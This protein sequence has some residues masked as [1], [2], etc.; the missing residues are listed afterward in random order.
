MKRRILV[1]IS[2]S[3]VSTSLGIA[4]SG[5]FGSVASAAT[6]PVSGDFVI[7]LVPAG[8]PTGGELPTCSP[9]I[10]SIGASLI[11]GQSSVSADCT[12][13]SSGTQERVTGTVS[14]PT[15][16]TSTGDAGFTSGTLALVCDY[17]H[18]AKLSLQIS[19]SGPKLTGLS[20]VAF[21]A[22]TFAM[23][24]TDANKSA[25][26]G[27]IEINGK[28]GSDDGTAANNAI[29]VAFDAKVYATQGS[30][31][32]AGYVGD[33]TFSQVMDIPLPSMPS[34]G[35]PS[36][37]TPSA[38][39]QA[40]I[41]EFCTTNSITDCTQTGITTWCR[42]NIAM[43]AK[44]LEL[45]SLSSSSVKAFSSRVKAFATDTAMN[46]D[47]V[48]KAGA[49]RILTP[50]PAAGSPT[51]V[52]KV[53]ATTKVRL[54]ATV[55]ATCTVKT[56]TGKIVGKGVSRGASLSVK[57]AAGSYVGAKTL[58]ATCKAKSGES[59]TSNKVKIKLG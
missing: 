48:K 58:Q 59:F 18:D 1:L 56:N 2:A 44:C 38:G 11:G 39:A 22:C 21:Q 37:A 3:L 32:F 47:L 46:L 41:Q 7:N 6:P 4:A 34:G 43:L 9:D 10:V 55:G 57:P 8:A 24:F 40:K 30:G 26:S 14:N 52:A 13:A 15:L 19:K 23:S 29:A 5:L 31:A 51:A 49:A 36:A 35:A 20:G 50:A 33:G 25:L 27:T 45:Q 53:K 28:L 12:F 17:T 54:A 42:N 16:A